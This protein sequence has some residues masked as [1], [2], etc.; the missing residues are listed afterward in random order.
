MIPSKA[1]TTKGEVWLVT[2]L[3]SS[4]GRIDPALGFWMEATKIRAT[5]LEFDGHK[6]W[7]SKSVRK[8]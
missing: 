5:D 7:E 2:S 8:V 1:L 6:D 3:W 4:A